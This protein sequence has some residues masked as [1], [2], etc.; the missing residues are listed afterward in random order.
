[1]SP[2]MNEFFYGQDKDD[3]ENDE[4]NEKRKKEE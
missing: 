1:M 4:K 3:E 2:E